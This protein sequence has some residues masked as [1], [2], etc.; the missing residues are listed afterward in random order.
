MKFPCFYAGPYVPRKRSL[1]L[2][3]TIADWGKCNWLDTTIKI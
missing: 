1:N 2:Q 3:I